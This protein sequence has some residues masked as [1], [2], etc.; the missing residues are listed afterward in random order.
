MN[1]KKTTLT[2]IH[3]DAIWGRKKLYI[4][5]PGYDLGI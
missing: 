1:V 4:E 5:A 3:I 2:L